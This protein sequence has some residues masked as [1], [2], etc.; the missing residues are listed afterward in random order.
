MALFKISKGLKANLPSK[1]TEGY[2][3]YTTDDSLFYIDYKDANGTLQRKALN[4]KD[5]ETL[6]G[7]S[8][9]TILNSNNIEIPTSK[10]VLDALADKADISHT[11]DDRYYTETEIDTKLYGKANT[12]HDHNDIYY[13][14]DKVK[15]EL[16]NKVD[17]VNGKGLSTNDYTTAEKNKL[18]GIE[19]GAQVNVKPDWSQNDPAAPDYI[20]NRT[21]YKAQ[22]FETL[23]PQTTITLTPDTNDYFGSVWYCH[24][25]EEFGSSSDV[26]YDTDYIV[27]VNGVE[28]HCTSWIF[29]LS[30]CIGDGRLGDSNVSD[31]HQENVPFFIQHEP[32]VIETWDEFSCPACWGFYFSGEF[33]D[34]VDIEIKKTTNITY[35]TLPEEF[36]PDTI[37]R[38]HNWEQIYNSGS[39]TKQVSAFANIRIPEYKS[40]MVAVKCVNTTKSAGSTGGAIIFN[41]T[42]GK[43]YAFRNILPD[44]ITNNV[45]TTGGLAIFRILDDYIV[46]E[47][48]MRSTNAASMLSNVDGEGGDNLTPVGGGIVRCHSPIS[49][50]TITNTN[51]SSSYYFGANSSVTVWGCKA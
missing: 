50:L 1:K 48:A 43:S 3:Y 21:H 2:C 51:S 14:K 6:C 44:L 24:I 39:I 26:P 8:L 15:A 41:G 46:C 19:D 40:I 11:H 23:F 27:I 5:A 35:H 31:Y 7:A 38:V 32:E 12:S 33:S 18:A 28:Y 45:G 13:T 34:S 37:A 16:D 25:D 22:T 10:A 36:I 9:A 20:E 42:N 17:R 4:A 29:D 49:T 30:T 47:N